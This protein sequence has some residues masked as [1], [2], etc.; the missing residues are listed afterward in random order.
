MQISPEIIGNIRNI[1][2]NLLVVGLVAVSTG[3]SSSV[4]SPYQINSITDK[5]YTFQ[6]VRHTKLI[7][8]DLTKLTKPSNLGLQFM[9][10]FIPAGRIYSENPIE[11]LANAIKQAFLLKR[12]IL[13]ISDLQSD[14]DS[15]APVLMLTNI[16][17]TAF[18]FLV[19]RKISCQ[20]EGEL[21]LNIHG[22]KVQREI[23]GEYST[24]KPFAF[25]RELSFVYKQCLNDFAQKLAAAYAANN[26]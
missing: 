3:C 19:L 21:S 17:L 2:R 14:S 25:T 12:N 15:Q 18:D 8:S 16:S 4:L 5:I 6:D 9:L 24:W 10:I 13:E 1:L 22:L 11:D 23:S 7:I 20:I 26:Y